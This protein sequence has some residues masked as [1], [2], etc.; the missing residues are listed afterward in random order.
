MF[1]ERPAPVGSYALA[2]KTVSRR[3]MAPWQRRPSPS[4]VTASRRGARAHGRGSPLHRL[5]ESSRSKRRHRCN[6]VHHS[7]ER[8]A[9]ARVLPR[10]PRRNGRLGREPLH[11]EARQLVDHHE[12]RW[13]ANARQARHLRGELRAG[14]HDIDLYEP[15][16]RRHQRL[17]QEVERTGRAVSDAAHRPRRG[18]PL[19][20]AGPRRLPD[21]GRP[22]DRASV[23]SPGRKRPEDLPG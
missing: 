1:P 7:P 21:R 19:L 5:R 13:P 23:W 3:S 4:D 9:I 16:R 22:V 12:S 6:H 10:R 8:C 14:R 20:Y 15:A 18:D 11:G 2:S 17:L